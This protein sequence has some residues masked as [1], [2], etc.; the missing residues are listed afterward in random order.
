MIIILA[1]HP[2]DF[3]VTFLRFLLTSSE[4]NMLTKFIFLLTTILDQNIW[5]T[6]HKTPSCTLISDFIYIMVFPSLDSS[7]SLEQCWS[8]YKLLHPQHS[9]FFCIFFLNIYGNEYV[10]WFLACTTVITKTYPNMFLFLL[11]IDEC[12]SFE[13]NEC[14]PNAMCTNTEGSYVCRCKRGYSGDG[15]N[16]SGKMVSAVQNF[17]FGNFQY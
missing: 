7:P 10:Q 14:H 8:R 1:E 5:E 13:T 16:C 11:D 15:K 9:N 4:Y 2:T 3:K 17:L 6:F 12:A